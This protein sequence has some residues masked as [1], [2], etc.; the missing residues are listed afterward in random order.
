MV[1]KINSTLRKM[2]IVLLSVVIFVLAFL[3]WGH[4]DV[5]LRDDKGRLLSRKVNSA[6]EGALVGLEYGTYLFEIWHVGLFH[7][8]PRLMRTE[9][10]EHTK[11]SENSWKFAFQL[12][13]Y[14]RRLRADS[15]SPEM[16]RAFAEYKTNVAVL[17]AAESSYF[18]MLYHLY[19]PKNSIS[20]TT[21][22]D[23]LLIHP[24]GIYLF[25]N[26]EWDGWIY[27]DAEGKFWSA[28]KMRNNK[29]E[30]AEFENPVLRSI[31]NEEALRRLFESADSLPVHSFSY[32]VF[33]DKAVLKH[34]PESSVERK[35]VL[36]SQLWQSLERTF[37]LAAPVYTEKEV[38]AFER[39][40]SG[41]ADKI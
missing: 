12:K 10:V 24:T 13:D 5:V 34:A 36:R 31:R 28:T 23:S 20:D 41:F 22:I 38:E 3:A 33:G 40:L 9:K 29:T 1:Q 2:W 32:V 14:G 21:T 7:L 25:E 4:D 26:A 19:L 6:D 39:E 16:R 17:R 8:K 37:S 18:K 11:I 27:G 15:K 30:K 35:I